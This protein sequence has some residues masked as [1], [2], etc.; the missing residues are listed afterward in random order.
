MTGLKGSPWSWFRFSSLRLWNWR[1]IWWKNV[2]LYLCRESY[3]QSNWKSQ[4]WTFQSWHDTHCNYIIRANPLQLSSTLNPISSPHRITNIQPRQNPVEQ[5]I[6]KY[7]VDINDVELITVSS[8]TKHKK[9][10]RRSNKCN[11]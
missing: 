6:H 5:P 7:I 8:R 4:N 11:K 2:I 10:Y 1:R 3:F 9:K